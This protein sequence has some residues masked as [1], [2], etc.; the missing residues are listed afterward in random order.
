MVHFLRHDQTTRSPRHLPRLILIYDT[1]TNT[2]N[3]VYIT[4]TNY[5]RELNLITNT[6]ITNT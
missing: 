6:Y 3:I 1:S 2:T 4:S 5:E